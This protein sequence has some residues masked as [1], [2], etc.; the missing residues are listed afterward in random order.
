MNEKA[1][2]FMYSSLHWPGSE[3]NRI[4]ALS[5]LGSRALKKAPKGE[6]HPRT[7]SALP[8]PCCT[9]TPKERPERQLTG[10]M[11]IGSSLK[12]LQGHGRLKIWIKVTELRKHL[13]LVQTRS[14]RSLHSSLTS[15]CSDVA[16]HLYVIFVLLV[17]AYHLKM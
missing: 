11:A 13:D 17:N 8:V 9:N 2:L 14:H 10:S 6:E 15:L 16:F 12:I 5:K 4:Y 7:S 3:S 1:V